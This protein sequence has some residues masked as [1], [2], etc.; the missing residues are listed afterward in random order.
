MSNGYDLVKFGRSETKRSNIKQ[1]Y[2][3][4]I[5][6]I[7]ENDNNWITDKEFFDI[8]KE[9]K[10]FL[11]EKKEIDIT[12]E[13]SIIKSLLN[14]A[15]IE[16]NKEEKKLK[17]ISNEISKKWEYNKYNQKFFGL[18]SIDFSFFQAL[19][20][21]RY[22]SN[23]EYKSS[24]FHILDQLTKKNKLKKNILIDLNYREIIKEIIDNK[25]IEKLKKILKLKSGS[26]N[27]L[28]K[29]LNDE[30]IFTFL[31][32]WK[33][34]DE[35]YSNLYNSINTIYKNN[36]EF[37][38]G[39]SE[40]IFGYK[41][42]KKINIRHFY[43]MYPEENM[44]EFISQIKK[45]ISNIEARVIDKI[46][47]GSWN[48][49]RHLIKN[50][51]NSLDTIFE[52]NNKDEFKIKENFQYL[53]DTILKFGENR[54]LELD[55][56]K[57]YN[58]DELLHFFKLKNKKNTMPIVNIIN[59]YYS[60]EKLII[61]FNKLKNIYIKG[62]KGNNKIE[63]IIREHQHIKGKVDFPTFFEF[64]IGMAFL[65]K[66]KSKEDINEKDYLEK[67]FNTK[68]DTNLCPIRF[69]AGRKTDIYIEKNDEQLFLNIE[70]TTQLTNQTSMELDSVRNHLISAINKNQFPK[71]ICI[72]VA[73]QI[74]ETLS[75]DIRGWNEDEKPKLEI[76]LFDIDLILKMLKSDSDIFNF[77]INN[78]IK[79][80][81]L[82]NE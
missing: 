12:R 73:P 75:Q 3:L 63:T 6:A 40:L 51:L 23:G 16:E 25:D 74:K 70:P 69:A 47:S 68:L 26:K 38:D 72:I 65:S 43:K 29:E 79:E 56:N 1:T 53:I 22:K 37:S 61:L 21:M 81:D 30:C 14:L 54:I 7:N 78:K 39:I 13:K 67:H 36:L 4:L 66:N 44:N 60:N 46:I 76:K 17:F 62:H 9:K 57:L 48:S 27:K 80:N 11:E 71:G 58:P 41:D 15:V 5:D 82:I 77:V 49:Y 10:Y 32:I 8:L 45:S 59:E 24:F 64:I 34:N 31:N 42:N 50:H 52:F 55:K 20:K 18:S 19:L 2:T 35:N 33:N 28:K